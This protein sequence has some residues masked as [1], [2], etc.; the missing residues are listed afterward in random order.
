MEKNEN[1]ERKNLKKKKKKKL[2]KYFSN[3]YSFIF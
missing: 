3:F 1:F 2:R